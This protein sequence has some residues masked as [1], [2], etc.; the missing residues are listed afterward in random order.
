MRGWTVGIALTMGC[1]RVALPG[2][3]GE[4]DVG[5]LTPT[6]GDSPS[7]SDTAPFAR[8]PTVFV[9]AYDPIQPVGELGP[10]VA[11]VTGRGEVGLVVSS[12]RTGDVPVRVEPDGSFRVDPAALPAGHHLLTF[13][14]TDN[15][16]TTEETL[17]LGV[18]EWPPPQD[19]DSP[20]AGS[21]W[22]LYGDASQDP[23]GWLEITG[24]ASAR[25]GHIYWTSRKIP[26]GDFEIAFDIATGGGANGGADG[27]AVNVVD[28]ADVAALEAWIAQTNNGG[29]LGYGTSGPCG[30]VAVDAFHVEFDT[31]FNGEFSD[32]TAEN[33]VAI[34][35]NGDPSDILLW[36]LQP[37][38][39]LQWRR[40]RVTG[41]GTVVSVYVDGVRVQQ[42]DIPDFRF[43]GGYLGVSGSTGWAYNYHRF[44]NLVVRDRCAVPD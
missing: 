33:H 9:E 44:D 12:D 32:P 29:C 11:R 19:F 41:R 7:I 27:Y 39:D 1:S 26:P 40:I 8:G 25:S 37:L 36:A 22:T 4:T 3:G 10:I 15:T 13:Y 24:N 21:G 18:C 38:E 23:G 42:A 6:P 20:I 34:A 16:G 2:G 35:R 14:G 43:E 30:E 17:Y 31:W 5:P 28:V